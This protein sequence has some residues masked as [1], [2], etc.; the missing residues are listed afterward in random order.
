MGVYELA[1]KV[2]LSL[3]CDYSQKN[4]LKG[5]FHTS[6]MNLQSEP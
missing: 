4:N 6:Q 2:Q 5:L 3:Y 1:A